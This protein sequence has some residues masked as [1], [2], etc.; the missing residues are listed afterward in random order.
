MCRTACPSGARLVLQ[1][2]KSYAWQGFRMCS[3]TAT[4]AK[5]NPNPKITPSNA[6][7]QDHLQNTVSQKSGYIDFFSSYMKFI[8]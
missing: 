3:P 4:N 6:L 8:H 2:V 5:I 7:V 1:E